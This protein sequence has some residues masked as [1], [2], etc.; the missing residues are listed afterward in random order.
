MKLPHRLMSLVLATTSFLAHAESPD[1]LV[2]TK[3]NGYVTMGVRESSAPLSYVLGT[4]YVGYHVELCERVLAAVLPDV[5]IRYQLVTSQ[6]RIPLLQNGTI[7]IE[8]G[9]TSNTEARAQQVAFANTT[10]ITEA[11][12]AVKSNSGIT[13]VTD[14]TGRN[15]VTTAGTTLLPRLRK[16]ERQGLKFGNILLGKDHADSF[17]MLESGRADAFAMD[18]STL[19]GNIASARDPKAYR[20]V[21]KPLGIE[22]IAIMLRKDDPAFKQAVDRQIG[23][24]MANGELEKLYSK[25]FTKP[26]PPSGVAMGLPL[27]DSLKEAFLHPNDKSAESYEK[28]QAQ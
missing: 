5:R 22:P 7:D 14:L 19:A 26:I 21:G 2:K 16:L 24:M 12:L 15:V 13:Q 18:D 6:N 1:T 27:S 11:R 20:I 4:H 17:L 8:C 28:D 23:Q 10:Y 3:A 9:S 25:W